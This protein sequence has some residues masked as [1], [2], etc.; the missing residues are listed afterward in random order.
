MRL[1]KDEKRKKN[2]PT[3]INYCFHDPKEVIDLK[4]Q[5]I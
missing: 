5:R 2:A 4:L 3:V 1:F